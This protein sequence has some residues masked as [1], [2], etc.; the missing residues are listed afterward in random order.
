[1]VTGSPGPCRVDVVGNFSEMSEEQDCDGH[2]THVASVAA[3][4]TVG[5]AKEATV[6][7]VRVLDCTGHVSRRCTAIMSP[8]S[9]CVH[10]DV[11]C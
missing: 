6:V 10:A 7:A 11:W 8:E 5:V 4:R 3:G 1:M 2:G 9:S